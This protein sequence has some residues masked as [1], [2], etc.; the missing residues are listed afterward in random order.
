MMLTS[1]PF[2]N[3][4]LALAITLTLLL[5][6]ALLLRSFSPGMRNH[7]RT[8]RLKKLESLQLTPH[9][10]LHLLEVDGTRHTVI[11]GPSHT[12]TLPEANR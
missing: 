2:L 4:L 11:T 8:E 1:M 7:N 10:T 5:G 9:H 6:L 3:M 12:V